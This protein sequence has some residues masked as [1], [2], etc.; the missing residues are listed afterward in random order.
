[1]NVTT[2]NRTRNHGESPIFLGN[3]PVMT[4]HSRKYAI[5]SPKKSPRM[6][7]REISPHYLCKKEPPSWKTGKLAHFEISNAIY[8]KTS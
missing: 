3:L 1:M 6:R 5:I 7:R 4:S 2:R 8:D